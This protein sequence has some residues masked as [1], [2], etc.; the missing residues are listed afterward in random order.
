LKLNEEKKKRETEKQIK[1]Q[2][3]T[4]VGLEEKQ[5]IVGLQRVK[6]QKQGTNK[7][8][9]LE[10]KKRIGSENR[11][12]NS[13]EVCQLNVPSAG[14]RHG[15]SAKESRSKRKRTIEPAVST[16]AD[17]TPCMYCE[18]VYNESAVGWV[19][20]KI[21]LQWAYLDCA[22]ISKKKVYVCDSCK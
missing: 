17:T 15:T 6:R 3:Q 20:C 2:K 11:Q 18:I 1:R 4:G 8:D 9:K 14:G 22:R 16:S 13:T 21:C 19:K 10:V 7:K 12:H 5:E